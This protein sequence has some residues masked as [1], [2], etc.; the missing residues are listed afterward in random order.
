LRDAVDEVQ[1]TNVAAPDRCLERMW[2]GW[3]LPGRQPPPGPLVP[4]NAA[5][6]PESGRFAARLRADLLPAVRLW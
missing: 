6:V 4:R 5:L 3:L 1:A 2:R